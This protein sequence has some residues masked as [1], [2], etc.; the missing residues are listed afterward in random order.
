M[1]EV[2]GGCKE[3]FGDVGED[4]VG[5]EDFGEVCF[6]SLPVVEDFVAVAG[7]FEAFS[8][9]VHADY[10]YVCKADLVYGEA[11]P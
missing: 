8:V 7:D 10:G 5:L 6:D 1:Q 3:A 9:A 11:Y 4:A 2:G